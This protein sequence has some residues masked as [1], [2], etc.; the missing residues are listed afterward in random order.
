M[1]M[2]PAMRAPP[3]RVCSGRLSPRRH[4]ALFGLRA[5]VGE[6]ALGGLDQ[7]GGLV[8][9]DRGDLGIEVD[10]LASA[11]PARRRGRR[12][13]SARRR[14]RRVPRRP[15]P[16]VRGALLGGDARIEALVGALDAL[17]Q[18]PVVHEVAGRTRPGAWPPTPSPPCSP[19]AAPGPGVARPSAAAEGAAQPVIERLGEADA[20]A[21]LRHLGAARERVAG[22]VDLLGQRRAARAAAASR[23][24]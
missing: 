18:L 8:G 17:E 6:R 16:G 20:V 22:A 21:R 7:L 2:M 9:E 14:G 10:R 12:R 24:R 4:S 13:L 5:P 3:F 11:L 23:A 15:A 19:P 1:G